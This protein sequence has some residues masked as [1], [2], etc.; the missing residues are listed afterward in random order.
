[1]TIIYDGDCGFC[2]RSI[3]VLRFADILKKF[4]YLDFH[5]AEEV[6]KRFPKLKEAD[7]EEAMY[8]VDSEGKTFRGFF[9]FRRLL[10]LSPVLWIGLP[11]FY[12]PGAGFVGPRVYAWIARNRKSISCKLPG[13]R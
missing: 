2:M 13:P 7:F 9:A 10:W 12:F 8:A 11:I 5:Q 4:E 3:R 1:M 6:A